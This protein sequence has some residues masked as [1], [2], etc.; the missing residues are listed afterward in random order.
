MEH[1]CPWMGRDWDV[2]STTY[3]TM[4]NMVLLE[5]VHPQSTSR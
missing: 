5:G 4:G 1:L 3:T 2:L